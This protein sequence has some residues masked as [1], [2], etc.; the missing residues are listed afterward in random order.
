MYTPVPGGIVDQIIA[1]LRSRE[2]GALITGGEIASKWGVP[3]AQQTGYLEPAL[4]AG[5]LQK[6]YRDGR[7]EGYVLARSD[8]RREPASRFEVDRDPMSGR[9]E[10]RGAVVVHGTVM[11]SVQ[12]WAVITRLARQRIRGDRSEDGQMRLPLEAA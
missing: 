3:K 12:Q 10:I 5:R 11:L 2:P 9:Y 1:D 6:R 4:R 7:I 8:S